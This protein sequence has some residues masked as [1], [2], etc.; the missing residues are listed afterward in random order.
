MSKYNAFFSSLSKFLLEYDLVDSSKN[1]EG[2]TLSIIEDLE[3]TID[4][5]FEVVLKTFLSRFGAKFRTRGRSSLMLAFNKERILNAHKQS[6]LFQKDV[7][8]ELSILKFLESDANRILSIPLDNI[9]LLDYDEVAHCYTIIS[10][11]EANP[12]LYY[13]FGDGFLDASSSKFTEHIRWG[14]FDIVID[15]CKT[16]CWSKESSKAEHIFQRFQ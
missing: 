12:I 1:I 7:Y 4:R 11:Q 5:K 16:S 8:K 13:Y 15:I 3:D 2:L 10:N 14:V 6:F 9:T